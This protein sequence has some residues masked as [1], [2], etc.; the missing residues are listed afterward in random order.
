MPTAIFLSQAK[1]R[2]KHDGRLKIPKI[3][4]EIKN[5]NFRVHSH[6]PLLIKHNFLESKRALDLFWNNL[7]EK[8]FRN[9]RWP[10]FDKNRDSSYKEERKCLWN[11]APLTYVLV[12]FN[13][14]FDSR[15]SCF[16]SRG[17]VRSFRTLANVNIPLW[18]EFK[19][20]RYLQ[21][22]V[23]ESSEKHVPNSFHISCFIS[24]WI[25]RTE[26]YTCFY[27]S[28]IIVW[29]CNFWRTFSWILSLY[30]LCQQH[31]AFVQT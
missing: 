10:C 19:R 14:S 21:R 2:L 23:P 30:I 1:F 31:K 8:E 6:F 11:Q 16:F 24:L 9:M 4:S 17:E 28:F 20:F 12:V 5:T 13:G 29:S 7:D 18:V 3:N 15:W 26:K 22:T 27:F 25:E